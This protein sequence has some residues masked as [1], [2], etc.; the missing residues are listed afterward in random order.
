MYTKS[1]ELLSDTVE[2]FVN[3]VKILEYLCYSDAIIENH[4]DAPYSKKIRDPLAFMA[5]IV[6][7]ITG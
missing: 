1:E 6:Y 4:D 7:K 2:Q 5:V 3:E